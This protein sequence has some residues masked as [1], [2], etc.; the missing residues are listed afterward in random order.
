[1]KSR[2]AGAP[3]LRAVADAGGSVDVSLPDGEHGQGMDTRTRTRSRA[4]AETPRY[5][6]VKLNDRFVTC[7]LLPQPEMMPPP[8]ASTESLTVTWQAPITS[9]TRGQTSSS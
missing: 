4:L 8:E 5:F 9:S 2:P 1:M 3:D 7:P 6:L